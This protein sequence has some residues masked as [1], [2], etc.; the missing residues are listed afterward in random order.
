MFLRT[1]HRTKDGKRHTYFALV[2]SVRTGR[3]PRQ[4]IIA[5]LGELSEDQ[6]R[7]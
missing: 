2:E 5:H 6:Q 4:R 3:G 1:Y 7:R